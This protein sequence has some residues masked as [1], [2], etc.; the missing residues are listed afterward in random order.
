MG[1]KRTKVDYRQLYKDYYG[2]EF[3]RDMV[4]HHID[5]DRTNNNID[6][7]LLLPAKL[8]AKYHFTY[9]MLFGLKY[10]QELKKDLMLRDPMTYAFF[11]QWLR[12]MAE[13]IEEIS[14]WMR[15][16]Y[17]FEMWPQDIYCSEYKTNRVITPDHMGVEYGRSE[18]DQ[19]SD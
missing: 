3:G 14:P 8:H 16:K 10:D 4:V 1:R 12:K 6:N 17:D 2:I 19:D 9:S 5:F 13:T 18:M 15:M 7:L 11:P